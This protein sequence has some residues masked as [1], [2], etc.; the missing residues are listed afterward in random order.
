MAPE[1]IKGEAHTPSVDWWSLGVITYEF[2]TGKPPFNCDSVDQ[3]FEKILKRDFRWPT[4]ESDGIEFTDEAKDFID[5]LLNP[6]PKLRLGYNGIDDIKKHPFFDGI[7]WDKI[8]DLPAP[9]KPGGRDIDTEYFPKANDQDKDLDNI[10]KDPML[11]SKG[12]VKNFNETVYSSLAM[13]NRKAASIALLR[14]SKSR[15]TPLTK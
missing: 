15:K 13:I 9:F 7:Q 1:I 14:A 8:M 5:R 2:L 3:V 10:T 11:L 4:M 12:N 6:N